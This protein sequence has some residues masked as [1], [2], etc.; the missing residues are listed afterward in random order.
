[1][2]NKKVLASGVKVDAGLEQ[3]HEDRHCHTVVT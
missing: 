3:R 2:R 1:L